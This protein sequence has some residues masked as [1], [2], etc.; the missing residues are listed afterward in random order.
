M[1]KYLPQHHISSEPSAQSLT[2]SQITD[3][4]TQDVSAQTNSPCVHELLAA[5]SHHEQ[6]GTTFSLTFAAIISSYCA[7]GQLSNSKF[8]AADSVRIG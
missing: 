6:V 3:S 5:E 4:G 7:A 2:V 1:V 8:Y